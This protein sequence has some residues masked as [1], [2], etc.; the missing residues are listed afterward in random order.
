MT[1]ELAPNPV[2]NHISAAEHY[3]E[4]AK[5][6]EQMVLS[7][8]N[9]FAEV[10]Q[11]LDEAGVPLAGLQERVRWLTGAYLLALQAEGLA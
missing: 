11:I 10:M 9:V 6:D 3:A 1:Y 2:T 8:L 5:S 4:L 7:V